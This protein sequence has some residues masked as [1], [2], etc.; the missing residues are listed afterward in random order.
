MSG[1]LQPTGR[2]W[3]IACQY[4]GSHAGRRQASRFSEHPPQPATADASRRSALP[5]AI[6]AYDSTPRPA[7]CAGFGCPARLRGTYGNHDVP[8]RRITQPEGAR[9]LRAP[10]RPGA[11]RSRPPIFLL[12]F[13]FS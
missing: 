3:V 13:C 11:K 2:R 8:H 6:P 4:S 12:F 7:Y 9:R 5:V 10:R 1:A